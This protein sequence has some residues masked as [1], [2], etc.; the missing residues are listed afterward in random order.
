[1]Q[2]SPVGAGAN[3]TGRTIAGT[4]TTGA[5]T[6]SGSGGNTIGGCAPV[7]ARSNTDSNAGGPN[8][9]SNPFRCGAGPDALRM[10][11]H[12]AHGSLGSGR[13]CS[14]AQVKMESTHVL[15]EPGEEKEPGLVH[16]LHGDRR[17][18]E[19]P[20]EIGL[21]TARSLDLVRRRRAGGRPTPGS[22]I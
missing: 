6:M 20:G 10:G 17:S 2:A 5:V 12:H 15:I 8:A 4:G 7:G 11:D 18:A 21:R 9:D 3:V 16:W 14:D 1:M 22:T 19:E 13:L